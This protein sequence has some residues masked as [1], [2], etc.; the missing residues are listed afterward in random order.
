M[1]LE[2]KLTYLMPTFNDEKYI[3]KSIDSIINQSFN[4]WELLI[5]DKSTDNTPKIIKKFISE[6]PDQIQYHKQEDI[7]QLNALLGLA[8]YISG[9]YVMLIHSDD[10]LVSEN[11]I[12]IIM[13]EIVNSGADGLYSDLIL[14]DK[15]GKEFGRSKSFFS[16]KRM[17]ISGGGNCIP[18]HFFLKKEIFQ[19][20]VIPNYLI[21]NIPYYF[22]IKDGE[23][24]FPNLKYSINSWYS[25]RVYE[26][27][28]ASSAIGLFILI[29]GQIRLIKDFFLQK[30]IISPNIFSSNKFFN[31][32]L[33]ISFQKMTG[34]TEK[35][36][37][38]KKTTIKKSLQQL[39]KGLYIKKTVISKL[40][41][42]DKEVSV[43]YIE[44]VL[45]SINDFLDWQETGT[46]KKKIEI[47]ENYLKELP[48]FEGRDVRLFYSEYLNKNKNEK[49]KQLFS[50]DFDIIICDNEKTKEK[51]S[52]L[53]DFF[54][55]LTPVVLDN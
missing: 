14:V 54:N 2:Y 19:E 16:I 33:N 41:V 26:E 51:I 5:M 4:N 9:D 25:Y 6:Y 29:N 40:E 49:I 3:K 23:F 44:N 39:R 13:D 15:H 37:R 45:S 46:Y 32:I 53:M 1:S 8:P 35:M 31:K 21:R 50:K 11:I 10:F 43:N 27:N 55:Y 38:I 7:G 34:L 42:P 18:D 48:I 30:Y 28:L 24:D 52:K 12:E 22:S 47:N 36:V 17:I 20:Y